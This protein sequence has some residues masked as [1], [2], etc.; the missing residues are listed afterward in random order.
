MDGDECIINEPRP[1]IDD[2][3]S[4]PRPAYHLLP[5]EYYRLMRMPRCTA[6]DF[7][8]PILSGRGCPFKCTFCYRTDPGFRARSNKAIIEEIQYLKAEYGITYIAF[9]DDLLMVSKA[10][11]TSLCEDM[12]SA[13]LNVRWDCNGRLNYADKEVLDLMKRAGC[14]FI[15]YGIESVDDQ[16]LKNY[17]KVLTE[18]IVIHGVEATLAAGIS[19]GL[20]MMFGNYGDD[21][22]TLKKS[23]DFL[24][25]YDDG[26]QLRTIRPVTPYPGSELYD[27]A[28]KEGLLEGPADFYESKHV[29]SD[30]PAVNFTDLTDDEYL[31]GLC[32]AN[33]HL[34]VNY[35]NTQ[36]YKM[37]AV[38]DALYKNDMFRTFRGYHYPCQFPGE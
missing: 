20:N 21:L 18:E 22:D 24:L 25:R 27:R 31:D 3:D 19:P 2:I 30:L 33:K 37:L 11:T 17:R 32:D 34:L 36:K 1:V 23:V 26:S 10:R 7:I 29:N 28:I 35:Y 38:A 15:N 8:I 5:M 16:V 13:R 12:I 6:T 4:I 9:S 14:V